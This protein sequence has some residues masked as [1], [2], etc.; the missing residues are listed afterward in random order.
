[1][2]APLSTAFA[3]AV[4]II[5]LLGY[6]L[7]VPVVQDLR[8]ILLGWAVSLAAI[9]ALVGVVN[10]ILVHF[11]R[12]SAPQ[13]KDF[14]SLFFIIAFIATLVFGLLLGTA[15]PGYQTAIIAIIVPIE[16]SLMA[17]LAV[18]LAY[19]C[20]RLLQRRKG[21]M[22]I[23]FLVSTLVFLLFS[24]GFLAIGNQVPILKEI[25]SVINW[26]PA[27]GARGIL[28]GIALGSLTTGIRILMGADRPYSG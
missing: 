16:T 25:Q 8:V 7:A 26:L 4:G 18:S 14:Y 27:A 11:R 10:L 2:R 22:P 17:I 13:G 5:V 9:A 21:V 28:L 12:L 19:A 24:G 1:M 20:L 23:I 15:D 3:I 6:F